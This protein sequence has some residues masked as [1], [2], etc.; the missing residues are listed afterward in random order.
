VAF[1]KNTSIKKLNLKNMICALCQER[2][3]N[4][5]NT[6][7]LTDSIIRTCLNQNGSNERETG[8]YFDLSSETPYI[9]FNFQ[10]GTSIEK[11]EESLGRQASDEE[12]EIAKDIPFS[13]DNVFCTQCEDIFTSIETPFI[14]KILPAFRENDLTSKDII[15][16]EQNKILKM[17][18]YLQVWRTAIC[19]DK[20]YLD[21]VTLEKLRH[22]IL[23]HESI[24]NDAIPIFPI[25]VTYLQVLGVEKEYTSNFVGSTNDRDPNIIFM[26][27]FVIQ[28]FEDE[29]SINEIDFYGLNDSNDLSEFVNSDNIAFK[30]KILPNNKRLQILTA[31]ARED[32]VQKAI[33]SFIQNFTRRWFSIFRGFPNPF[34][35]QSFLDFIT[36][37]DFDVLQYTKGTIDDKIV[38]FINRQ[39][40]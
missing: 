7:Y 40:M 4:K 34:V 35:I 13:V 5:K 18:F 32:K 27:D 17:F 28:F 9:D 23:N 3:A 2:E 14:E 8:Y 38:E 20:F 36:N 12:I 15:E 16:F 11:L 29:E 33:S 6:H 22:T 24:E 31:L 10:R 25:H 39:L 19:E 21:E 26:N 1:T 37:G 30:F